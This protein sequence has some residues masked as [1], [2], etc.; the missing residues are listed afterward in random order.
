MRR[1]RLGDVTDRVHGQDKLIQEPTADEDPGRHPPWPGEGT[2]RQQ[3]VDVAPWVE[4]ELSSK[5]PGDRPACADPCER[6]FNPHGLHRPLTLERPRRPSTTPATLHGCPGH[7]ALRA[8]WCTAPSGRR[9]Q[10]IRGDDRLTG[11]RSRRAGE[12]EGL[13]RTRRRREGSVH[14]CRLVPRRAF[15]GSLDLHTMSQW[16][17][18]SVDS[19]PAPSV[20]AYHVGPTCS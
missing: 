5:D 15:R 13:Q 2:E 14:R 9:C 1:L 19:R 7:S 8:R 4:Q 3:D 6:R 16:R 12:V 17:R 20:R 11:G 18:G 10:G